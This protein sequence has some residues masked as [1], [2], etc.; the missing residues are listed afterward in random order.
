MAWNCVVP[1]RARLVVATIEGGPDQ[2]TWGNVAQSLSSALRI[3]DDEGVIV[4]CSSLQ[5]PPGA[6]LCRLAGCYTLD[7]AELEINRDRT[8]DAVA[9]WQLVQTLRRVKVY[10]MSRLEAEVVEGLGI[11]HVSRPEE[12]S[13]LVSRYSPCALL[14]NSQHAIPVLEEELVR[15]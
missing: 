8:P 5:S 12:I 1:R 15:P 3:V 9:A 14:A 4:V 11:G 6:S 2:Q 13:R 10:L 7:G